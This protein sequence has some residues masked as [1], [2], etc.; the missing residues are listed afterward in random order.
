MRSCDRRIDNGGASGSACFVRRLA[1]RRIAVA[2]RAIRSTS[3]R[4]T[5]AAKVR[6]TNGIGTHP[7][8]LDDRA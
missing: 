3:C 5:S 2:P 4:W 8:D 7:P 1:A 6:H